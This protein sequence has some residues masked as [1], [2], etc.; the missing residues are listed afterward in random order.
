MSAGPS[1]GRSPQQSGPLAGV[2]VLALENYLAGNHV[3][4]MLGMLG[5]EVIK[6]EHGAGDTMRNVGPF[7]RNDEGEKRS[8]GELRLM[9]N[10]RSIV[11]DLDTPEGHELLMQLVAKVDVFFTNQKPASMKARGIDFDALRERNPRIVYS[12]LSGFGHDDVVTSGPYGDWVA[13][14]VIAQGLSGVM[15]RASAE[16]G[17]TD[18]PGYNGLPLGDENTA[19]LTAMGTIS[20]LFRRERTGEAQRVDVAMH[21]AMIFANEQAVNANSLF[22]IDPRRGRSA[23]SAPYG[24]FRTTDGWVNIGVGGDPVW[25]RFCKATGM[26]HLIDDARFRGSADRVK[27]CLEIDPIVEAWTCTR[28]T[29]D[30][31]RVLHAETVPAAPVYTTPQ[32]LKSPQVAARQMLVPVEDPVV[33]TRHVVGNPIK[34]TGLDNTHPSPPPRL[35]ADTGA[36]L[37]ELLGLDSAA[38]AALAGRGVIALAGDSPS[39]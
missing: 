31:V 11:I 10:K 36:V 28:S 32:A 13:F 5:A 30:V 37:G 9:V 39:R 26:E 2:R 6:V 27:N 29:D 35:G 1:K 22:N 21:D 4:F 3:T 17:Q 18:K 16:G 7:L 12:T 8:A 19:L 38:I 23:T 25:R 24:V 20:A 15:F 33:G 34:V 14:D